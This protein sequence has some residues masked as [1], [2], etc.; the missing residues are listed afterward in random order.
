V[1]KRF[2]SLHTRFGKKKDVRTDMM[3]NSDSGA[4]MIWEEI[5][6]PQSEPKQSKALNKRKTRKIPAAETKL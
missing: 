5:N 3:S 6:H 2:A 1:I 4:K